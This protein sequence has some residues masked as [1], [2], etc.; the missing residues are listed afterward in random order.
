MYMYFRHGLL[1]T[2]ISMQ[3]STVI[4]TFTED[5]ICACATLNRA[6]LLN[7]VKIGNCI[8]FLLKAFT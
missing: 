5:H 7:E 2:R 8:I 4:E 3:R 6:V 1:C